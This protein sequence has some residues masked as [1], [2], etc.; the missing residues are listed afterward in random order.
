MPQQENQLRTIKLEGGVNTVTERYLLPDGS[1]ST[2]QNVRMKHPGFEQRLGC[3]KQHSTADATIETTTLYQFSK[4]KR[5][6]RIL[7]R[8]LSDGSVQIATD[9]PP[10]T[11]TGVFGSDILSNSSGIVPASYGNINDYMLY[12]D[13]SR[14]HQIYGGST[15]PILNVIVYKGS[16]TIAA[17]PEE[18]YDYTEEAID[19]S[20]T[21][22]IVLDSLGNLA[23]NDAVFIRTQLPCQDINLTVSSVNSN[24]CLLGVYYWNGAWTTVS[25]LSDGTASGGATL[26]QSG[27]VT[28]TA[29]T[30]ELPHYQFGRSGFWYKFY[31][32]TSTDANTKLLLHC[33]GTD[34]STTFTDSSTSAHTV[35]ANGNAQIDTAQ[36]K[37][38]GASGLF[39]GT[40]DYLSVPYNANLAPTATGD[41]T[42]DCWIRTTT[43]AA[44]Q[45]IYSVENN[46]TTEPTVYLRLDTSGFLFAGAGDTGCTAQFNSTASNQALS[47]NTWYHVAMVIDRTANLIK[48]FVGGVECTYS[49]QESITGNLGLCA[50]SSPAHIGSARPV[51]SYFNGW[52]DEL[53]VS[54]SARWTSNF[55][56][57]TV[58][59]ET[60]VLD[61]TVRLSAVTCDM[62][63]FVPLLNVWDGVLID[64]IEAQVYS[65]SNLNYFTYGASAVELSSL[66]AGDY[67]YFS[68]AYPLAGIHCDMGASPNIIKATF[69]G[70]SNLSFKD[71]GSGYDYIECTSG[72]FLS[73]GFE[74]GMSI[75]IT[76]SASNNITTSIANIS[77]TTIYVPTGVFT[78]ENNTS[79]TITFTNTTTL[80]SVET[81]ID[82]V[83]TAVTGL[84]D[85]TG[86]I[87]KSGFITWNRTS[88]NPTMTQF[89]STQY[90][91][92]W[93][94]LKYDVK[95][96]RGVNC[97]VTCIPYFDLSVY[98]NGVCNAVW[99]ERALYSFG[100]QFIHVS[101]KDRFTVLNGMDYD[102]LE[103]GDGRNNATLCMKKFYNELIAWQ[104]ERGEE[105]GC[106]TIFEGYNPSTYGKLLLS[107]RIGIMNAKC[108]AIV[109]GVSTATMSEEVIRVNAFW[110]SKYGVMSTKGKNASIDVVSDAIGNYFDPTKSEYINLT[111]KNKMWLVH[112][113]TYN[114]IRIGLVS[115]NSA[116][117]C[118]IFPVLDLVNGGWSFDTLGQPLTHMANIEAASGA[119]EILQVGAGASDGF[120]YQL[121]QTNDDVSTAV[122]YQVVMELDGDGKV[123]DLKEDYFRCKVQSSGNITRAIA[124]NGNSAYTIT[125]NFSMTAAVANDLYRRHRSPRSIAAQHFSIK[126]SNNTANTP[127]TMTDVGFRFILVEN[128]V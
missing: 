16:T 93:Y 95:L 60:A 63:T 97:G 54:N 80:S 114:V 111:Y 23:D 81:M 127:V 102:I 31:I 125:E 116:T 4:G 48:L 86:G 56:P 123:I 6:E 106:T 89:N 112:D 50:G 47:I 124:L 65:S 19:N 67:W 33:N 74:I 98:G 121:N 32:Y 25:G 44:T 55:T 12:S 7:F 69:T 122:N 79:A 13:G 41:W 37:F 75:V 77:S 20:A 22:Y 100:D 78:A 10:S 70:S 46:G 26:A 62:N 73:A 57:A 3:I 52:I 119:K 35:T 53:R 15:Q 109:D 68:S 84:S 27:S 59:Y 39:D 71:G 29:P 40:G 43:L 30:D 104:E 14:Q 38:G 5:V 17:I 72:D 82:G 96:S 66:R 118:N 9:N 36:S 21:T 94:R 101:A 120:V 51:A 103:A 24:G 108:S 90:Y 61:S 18:G 128:N 91:A 34:A 126:W 76:G 115:G 64:A 92:Y 107:D 11:T 45:V 1:F 28:W 99:K 85:A 87:S 49:V 110:L 58:A 8:Q 105:G 83:W 113:K 42:L 2:L 117:T 88:V